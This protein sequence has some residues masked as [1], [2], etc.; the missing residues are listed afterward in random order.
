MNRRKLWI[1]GVLAAVVMLVAGTSHSQ[2]VFS[3]GVKWGSKV[4]EA[5]K[6]LELKGDANAGKEVYGVCAACH[7]P[8][9]WGDPAGTFP[10]LA[11]QHPTVIIKQI[12]DIRAG[13]RDNPTM[14]P[15]AIQIEGSQDLADLAAYLGTV[16]MNP[17]NPQGTGA[18]LALG[19]KLFEDNCVRCHGN[20]GE[21][22]VADS[23]PL[24][25]GQTYNYIVRQLKEI[26]DG[27]RRNANPDMV[28]QVNGFSDRDFLAVADFVSRLRTPN[29]LKNLE[30]LPKK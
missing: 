6:A 7:Q 21:G 10:Q 19:K 29:H 8:T 26:R 17:N 25:G 16:P 13:N 9:A 22:N 1:A 18:D 20:V 27:K 5:L 28:K 15:F 11:G 24:I 23:Y 2:N 4:E 3:G 30:K 14:Y 12:A